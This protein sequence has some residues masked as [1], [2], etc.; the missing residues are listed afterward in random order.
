MFQPEKY[1]PRYKELYI[2][3]FGKTISDAEAYDQFSSLFL[4]LKTIYK[5]I[6]ENANESLISCQLLSG[7]AFTIMGLDLDRYNYLQIK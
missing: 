4:L 6:P 1:I 7:V 2:K 5:P 3:R